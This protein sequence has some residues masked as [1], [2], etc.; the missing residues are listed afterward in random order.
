[1]SQKGEERASR[2][3]L[4]RLHELD[5]L[6]RR[7]HAAH[8]SFLSL[9][10]RAAFHPPRAPRREPLP[11]LRPGELGVTFVGHSTVL[12]RT[13]GVRVLTDPNLARWLLGLRRSWAP[14]LSPDELTPLDLVLV[15]HAH[16]DHLVRPSLRRV[17]SGATCVVPARCADLV[18]DLGFARVVE[19]SVGESFRAG[20]VEVFAV[21]A[22]HWGTRMLGDYKRRGYC[23]YVVR[24]DGA[25]AY[26]AGDTAYFS[27]FAEIGQRY[28]P[29][30]ALLPIGAYTPRSFRRSHMSPL[31]AVYALEDLGSRLLVP[32]HFGSYQ[33]SYEPL[34]EPPAWLRELARQRGLEKRVAI[35]ENGQS[36]VLGPKDSG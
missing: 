11:A 33:L 23:G 4:E 36:I 31:D 8:A 32:I 34:D 17:S 18:S 35:L 2:A 9:W 5:E 22:R 6:H 27:G 30:V 15:S 19:L 10:A 12:L 20:A 13:A 29:D 3:H 7:R 16:H 1:M 21:P 28:R 26:F 14:G 25:S 24:G